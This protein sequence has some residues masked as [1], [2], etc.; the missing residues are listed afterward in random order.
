MPPPKS[1]KLLR[2]ESAAADREAA[3]R[4]AIADRDTVKVYKP[5]EVIPVKRVRTFNDFVAIL[6]FRVESSILMTGSH[7]YKNEGMVVG[8]GPGLPGSDGKRVPSQLSIGDVVSFY[9]NP[10]TALEPQSG[11]Y[12]GQKIIIVPER[13][14][15]CGLKSVPF[16]LVEEET[17]QEQP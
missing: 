10:T 13:A 9:G 3:N 14:V 15:I 16:K 6:Q 2:E 4:Q 17:A 11:V 8:V 1:Q 12:A 7:G 5:G